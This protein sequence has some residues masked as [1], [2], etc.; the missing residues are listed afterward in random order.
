[1]S[2]DYYPHPKGNTLKRVRKLGVGLA[3]LM[4]LTGTMVV[5][6]EPAQA[7]TYSQC[8]Y[9]YWTTGGVTYKRYVCYYDYSIWEELFYPW[10]R[11]GWVFGSW[12]RA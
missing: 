6:A 11:D 3:A 12:R 10:Y 2:Y 5:S 8:H 4:L 1:M 7:A 9:D